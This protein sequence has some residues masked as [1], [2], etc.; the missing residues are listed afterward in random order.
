MVAVE[1]YL[2]LSFSQIPNYEAILFPENQT[3]DQTR[4]SPHQG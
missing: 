2:Y 1:D 3:S 4:I